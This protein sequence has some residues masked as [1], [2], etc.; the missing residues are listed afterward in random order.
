MTTWFTSDTHFGHARIVE[1]AGRPYK[2]VSHMN[3]GIIDGWNALVRPDD[4]VYHLGDV[5]LGPIHESLQCMSRL[6]GRKILIVGNHDRPFPP[7][8]KGRAEKI[9]E[10]NKVYEKYFDKIVHTLPF[11]V[12]DYRFILS[13]FPYNGDSNGDERFQEWRPVDNGVPIIHGHTHSKDKFTRSSKGTPQIH[14]GIDAW[15]A[16]VSLQAV[17]D[18]LDK[19]ES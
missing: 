3:E 5:A 11:Q 12:G 2:D 19:M 13:H 4:T 1:L 14:V 17:I 8:Q 15:E 16:P 10:W 7:M 18:L 6:N 9:A